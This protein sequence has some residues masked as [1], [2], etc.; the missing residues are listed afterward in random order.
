MIPKTALFLDHALLHFGINILLKTWGEPCISAAYI[1]YFSGMMNNCGRSQ[2]AQTRAKIL[3][4][5]DLPLCCG[6]LVS[7][8]V[9]RQVATTAG[10]RLQ[11]PDYLAGRALRAAL[12]PKNDP[13]LREATPATISSLTL[14]DVK[15]YYEFP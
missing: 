13:T 1:P 3:E 4:I 7:K 2:T 8:T 15:D 6:S 9:Q 14:Q 11:S 10:G 12:F 5:E